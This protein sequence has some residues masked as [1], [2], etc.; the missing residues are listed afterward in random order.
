MLY[1]DYVAVSQI[2]DAQEVL[3]YAKLVGMICARSMLLVRT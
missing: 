2:D 3:Q 1:G